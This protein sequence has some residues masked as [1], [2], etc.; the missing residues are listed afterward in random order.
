[1]IKKIFLIDDNVDGNRQKYGGG[2]V[3]D[4]LYKNSLVVIDKLSPDND[5]SFIENASCILLH[6]S[7]EDFFDGS[8]HDD[9]HKVAMQIR[10]QPQVGNSLPLVLFSDGDTND[11]GD[12]R[13]QTIFSLSKRAFYGRLESFVQHFQNE[14]EVE[15]KL[16]A[17]GQNYIAYLANRIATALFVR[18]QDLQDF[19]KLPAPRIHCD[20]M[21]QLVSWSQPLIGKTYIEIIRDLTL[22]PIS[23]REFKNRINNIIE[24]IQDY[25]KNIY[26]WK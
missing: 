10:K 14:H 1:M 8:F 5:I 13:G 16:L 17:Y 6:K 19:E 12:L 25:G 2:F 15:L 9:S 18:L 21:R 22:N 11:L 26:T 20:E 7:L 4:G 23:V 3:D 24:S